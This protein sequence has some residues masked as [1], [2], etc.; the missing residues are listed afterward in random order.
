MTKKS[1]HTEVQGTSKRNSSGSKHRKKIEFE[2]LEPRILLSAD[3][4]I[5]PDF[6]DAEED[7]HQI[8]EQRHLDQQQ[9]ETAVSTDSIEIRGL[10]EELTNIDSSTLLDQFAKNTQQNLEE[11]QHQIIIVDSS[12]PDYGQLVQRLVSQIIPNTASLI[13]SDISEQLANDN[14]S[15]SENVLI[16][17]DL[18]SVLVLNSQEDGVEQ[19]SDLLDSKE[20]IA[21][22]H[23]L[24][25]I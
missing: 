15:D 11:S 16:E 18:L 3:I 8:L 10:Q 6:S 13:H 2:A 4:G 19:I 20:N 1:R 9:A 24:S 17:S 23:L 25:H 5:A 22:I 21:A 7:S 12:I 14:Q